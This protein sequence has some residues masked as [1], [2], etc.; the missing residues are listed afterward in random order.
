MVVRS[1]LQSEDGAWLPR[2]SGVYGLIG[3]VDTGLCVLS[4][5]ISSQ[6]HHI[7]ERVEQRNADLESPS[8]GPE[9]LQMMPG[10]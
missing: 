3:M 8:K 7:S 1:R 4:H 10:P 2:S 9:S 5:H 6:N